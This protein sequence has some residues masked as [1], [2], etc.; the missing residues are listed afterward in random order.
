[1]PDLK[2]TGLKE[3]Q[4]DFAAVGRAMA[5]GEARA[6]RRVSITIAAN[7]ARAI[8]D[9]VNLRISTIKDA[10]A[11]AKYPTAADPSVVFEVRAKGIPLGDFLGSRVTSKGLSV[12]PLK[13][14]KRTILKAG[15]TNGKLNGKY[16]GRVKKGSTQYGSPHVGRLP[17]AKLFGPDVLSQYIKDAIQKVGVDTW[18]ARLEIELERETNFALQKAGLT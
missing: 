1:M 12:Q 5:A 7:Q 18:N 3:M 16:F 8:A 15:F 10:I 4:R 9:R 2:F 14:G 11:T 6:V 17:I 13:G